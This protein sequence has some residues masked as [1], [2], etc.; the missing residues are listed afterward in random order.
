[1]QYESCSKCPNL[2]HVKISYFLEASSYLFSYSVLLG[3]SLTGFFETLFSLNW[4]NP[5]RTRFPHLSPTTRVVLF[6]ISTAS[7]PSSSCCRHRRDSRLRHDTGHWTSS[8]WTPPLSRYPRPTNWSTPFTSVLL[9][10]VHLC[11]CW[12]PQC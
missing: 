11:H 6:P 5:Q 2:S 9:S 4:P 8:P 12:P 3:K 7:L 10:P 1:L